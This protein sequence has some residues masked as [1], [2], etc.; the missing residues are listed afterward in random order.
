MQKI[1]RKKMDKIRLLFFKVPEV[2]FSDCVSQMEVKSHENHAKI[3]SQIQKRFFAIRR[4]LLM[5]LG[6]FFLRKKNAE[7]QL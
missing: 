5:S 7:P 3:Q 2:I 6:R 4:L 1:E